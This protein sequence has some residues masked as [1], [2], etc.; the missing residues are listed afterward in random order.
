[1]ASKIFEHCL[2]FS[3]DNLSSSVRQFDFK[4]GIVVVMLLIEYAIQFIFLIVRGSLLTL[5]LLM[6]KRRSIEQVSGGFY[7]FF[8]RNLLIRLL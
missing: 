1:M 2:I 5:V 8:K 6:S 3:L 7:V 4:K